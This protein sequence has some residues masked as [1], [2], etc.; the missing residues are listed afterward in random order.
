MAKSSGSRGGKRSIHSVPAKSGAGWDV[1]REGTA[2]P[3]SHHR[4]QVTAE[5][6]A[7]SHAQRDEV[8]AV[9]HRKDGTIRDK[10]SSGHDPNPPRDRKP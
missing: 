2:E 10:D 6:A 3:L 1:K 8:E 7:R 5:K 4:T 9:F